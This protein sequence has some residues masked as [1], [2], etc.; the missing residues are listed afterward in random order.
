MVLSPKKTVE[1]ESYKLTDGFDHVAI[2]HKFTEFYTIRNQ[3][4]TLRTL[5]HASLAFICFNNSRI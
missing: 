2:Q 4:L 1:R 5:L 3:L